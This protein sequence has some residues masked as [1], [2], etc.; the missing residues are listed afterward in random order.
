MCQQYGVVN[1]HWLDF[2]AGLNVLICQLTSFDLIL[3]PDFW[4]EL[5]ILS[6]AMWNN[7]IC[8]KFGES[9]CLKLKMLWLIHPVA[10]TESETWM[11]DVYLFGK[12]HWEFKMSVDILDSLSFSLLLY[13]HL[14]QLHSF[15]LNSLLL[16]SVSLLPVSPLPLKSLLV[17]SVSFS[18]LL[19]SSLPER[20]NI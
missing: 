5:A 17:K 19:F 6:G 14:S 12:F 1:L 3:V 7:N 10:H 11:L 18:L 2:T 8:T 15:S 13:L 4:R 9:F 16:L 20:K